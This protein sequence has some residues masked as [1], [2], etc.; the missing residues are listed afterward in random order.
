MLLLQAG[1]GATGMS[2]LWL[3]PV[4]LPSEGKRNI[5]ATTARTRQNVQNLKDGL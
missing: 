4:P 5:L 3:I 2:P 1:P